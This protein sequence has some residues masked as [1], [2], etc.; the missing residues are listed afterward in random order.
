MV[1]TAVGT[2][3]AGVQPAADSI[4]AVIKTAQKIF[5]IL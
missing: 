1:G 2:G 4:P 5:I 3:V